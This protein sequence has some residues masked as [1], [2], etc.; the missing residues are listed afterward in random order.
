MGSTQRT[1]DPD[2]MSRV[3]NTIS[4]ARETGVEPVLDVLEPVFD[5]LEPVYGPILDSVLLK[6]AT[7]GTALIA[8][9]AILNEGVWAA[10]IAVWGA[11]LLLAG[12]VLYG[13]VWWRRN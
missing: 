10:I 8:L 13:L 12:L 5:A 9:G 1:D 2:T 11:G 3:R 4:R 6:L 7:A